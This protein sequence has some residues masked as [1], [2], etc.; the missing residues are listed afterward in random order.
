[1]NDVS[2]S[3]TYALAFD[4]DML[5]C[6]VETQLKQLELTNSAAQVFTCHTYELLA[7][8]LE[9]EVKVDEVNN[10]FSRRH[11]WF[12]CVNSDSDLVVVYSLA[13]MYIH[14]MRS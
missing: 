11:G 4:S 2:Q 7:M 12:A 13:F 3:L 8:R 1:M 6:L 10:N 14:V 9:K 5:C